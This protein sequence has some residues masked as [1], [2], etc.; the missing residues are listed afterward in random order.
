MDAI[1]AAIQKILEALKD[2]DISHIIDIL[3]EFF[4]KFA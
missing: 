1:F 2:I 3:K 4:I